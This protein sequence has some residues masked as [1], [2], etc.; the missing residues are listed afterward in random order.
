MD[1]HEKTARAFL[2]SSDMLFYAVVEYGVPELLE[3]GEYEGFIL[4]LANLLRQLEKETIER[5]AK[6]VEGELP[7]PDI[8]ESSEWKNG[9]YAMGR[10]HGKM[11]RALLEEE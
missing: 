10:K 2:N 7:E 6:V 1:K 9:A 3:S 11:I 5:C 4:N 8:R